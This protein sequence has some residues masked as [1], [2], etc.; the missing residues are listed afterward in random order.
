M[1]EGFFRPDEKFGP[2]EEAAVPYNPGPGPESSGVDQARGRN[3]PR[4][5]SIN[6]VKGIGI[7]RNAIGDDAIVVFV[8][9]GSVRARLPAD[10]DG[11]PVETVVTGEID[12]YR[13]DAP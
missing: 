9:D 13:S 8:V 1:T 7:G 4:L 2:V 6:G 11:Y 10:V 3:E 5:L 12:A